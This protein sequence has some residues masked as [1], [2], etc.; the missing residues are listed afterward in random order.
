ME[1]LDPGHRYKLDVFDGTPQVILVFM[2]RI[3]EKYPGNEPP[4]YGGTNL[5][6][7]WRACIDRLEYLNNQV[8][9]AETQACIELLK[10]CIFLLESRASRRHGLSLHV[11]VFDEIHTLQPCPFC[12]HIHCEHAAA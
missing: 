8:P 7:V 10:T 5:Q 1:I 3:G 9:C 2:K 6:E 11:S 12:G 4:A